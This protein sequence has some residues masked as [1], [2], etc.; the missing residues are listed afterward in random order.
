MWAVLAANLQAL[1]LVALCVV[2]APGAESLPWDDELCSHGP[3]EAHSGSLGCVVSE[4]AREAWEADLQR[5]WELLRSAVVRRLIRAG[6]RSPLVGYADEDQRRG[7]WHRN[8]VLSGS[9]GSVRF[10]VDAMA[11]LAPRYGFGY[12]DR[13]VRWRAGAAAAGYLAGYLT[14]KR[15]RKADAS[16]QRIAQRTPSRRKCWWMTPNLTT[17][18]RVTMKSLRL[19]RRCWAV[20]QGLCEPPRPEGFA[21]VDWQ[22]IDLS[23]GAVV[24]AVWDRERG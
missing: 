9:P 2:T 3:D 22:V 5:R 7:A 10:F 24:R 4:H 8:L 14:G 11:E 23:T 12:V 13:K 17:R 16:I 19:G 6:Y 21:V 15:G 20:S 1:D 18:S